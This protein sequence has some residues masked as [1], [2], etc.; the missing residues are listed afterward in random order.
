MLMVDFLKLNKEKITSE[1]ISDV[2]ESS[3]NPGI[4]YVDSVD[5]SETS[6]DIYYYYDGEACIEK[7]SSIE[8]F[9]FKVKTYGK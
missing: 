2:Y 7:F 9:R 5:I 4:D 8:D 3:L 6:I 1:I